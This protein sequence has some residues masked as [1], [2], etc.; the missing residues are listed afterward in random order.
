MEV[1]RTNY[2]IVLTNMQYKKTLKI[3][4]KLRFHQFTLIKILL[5]I[6]IFDINMFGLASYSNKHRDS[7]LDS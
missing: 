2:T 6:F 4:A 1:I 5:T 7:N 3:R